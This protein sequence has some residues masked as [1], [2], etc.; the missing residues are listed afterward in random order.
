M[1]SSKSPLVGATPRRAFAAAAT[2]AVALSVAGMGA[3]PA[4]SAPDASCPDAFPVSQDVRGLAVH[5]LTV[6]EGTKPEQF[7]GQVL[8]V[9]EDGIAPA[10]PMIM[11]KVTS[12]NVADIGI[13]QGMSGSPVYAPDGRLIGAVS[14]GLSFGPS[15]VA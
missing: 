2:A 4:Q 1:K 14:Y 5:G 10:L 7:D 11:V 6:T 13:W 8:G 15:E 12:P 9:L 3:A